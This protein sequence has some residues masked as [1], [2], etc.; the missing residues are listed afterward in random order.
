MPAVAAIKTSSLLTGIGGT[1]QTSDPA[2][3]TDSSF[4]P[5][6]FNQAGVAA[7]VNRASGIAVG[8]PRLTGSFREPTK[9]SRMFKSSWKLVL[10]TLEVTA[11]TTV[12]G[13]QPAPTKAYEITYVLDVIMPERCTLAERTLAFATFKSLLFETIQASDFSPSDATGSPLPPALINLQPVY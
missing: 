8:F 4:G 5:A 2:I 12:T 11:P 6:G 7:W 10:P 9:A 3:A 1:I 13:I